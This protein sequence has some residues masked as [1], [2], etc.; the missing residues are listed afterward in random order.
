MAAPTPSPEPTEPKP[1]ATQASLA[2]PDEPKPIATPSSV[3]EPQASEDDPVLLENLTNAIRETPFSAVVQKLR[4]DVIPVDSYEVEFVYHVRVIENIRGPKLKKLSYTLS[5]EKG[6]V[7][8]SLKEP[9]ILTLCKDKEGFYWPGPGAQF[10]PTKST[11]ALVHKIRRDLSPD[12][13]VF[14]QCQTP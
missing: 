9:V 10:P 6:E 11:L 4:V 14:Q 2:K 7:P 1:V 3:A 5:A 12:Q 13:K 8:G